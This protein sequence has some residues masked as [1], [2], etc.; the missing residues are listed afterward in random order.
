MNSDWMMFKDALRRRIDRI[1][2]E[3]RDAE[4]EVFMRWCQG[5]DQELTAILD[6][7]SNARDIKYLKDGRRG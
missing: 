1:H 4:K 2:D 3:M 7:I 5:R 6:S